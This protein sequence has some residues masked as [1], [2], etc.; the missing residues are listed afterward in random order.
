MTRQYFLDF[1]DD[2]M[3]S[4]TKH[5]EKV[6]GAGGSLDGDYS[7]YDVARPGAT[8][9]DNG[10]TVL[11]ALSFSVTDADATKL[12]K[13][14]LEGTRQGLAINGHVQGD[15]SLVQQ[16]SLS[17]TLAIFD[18]VDISGARGAGTTHNFQLQL[19]N[20]TVSE[21]AVV[22]GAGHNG[23]GKTVVTVDRVTNT[24]SIA[25]EPGAAPL[26]GADAAGGPAYDD[27]RYFMKVTQAGATRWVEIES[28]AF[29]IQRP[30]DVNASESGRGDVTTFS[31][32]EIERAV[33]DASHRFQYLA[34]SE[35]TSGR[36]DIQAFRNFGTDANPQWLLASEYSFAN[37][38]MRGDGKPF[39]A[40]VSSGETTAQG[41]LG[42]N[43]AFNV[44]EFRETVYSYAPVTFDLL[45]QAAIE[46]STSRGE[47]A[48]ELGPEP[49][50]A[51]VE[52]ETGDLPPVP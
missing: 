18:R 11:D 44:T 39:V 17:T 21:D 23:Q 42:E 13:A 19:G 22:T 24:E 5:P 30:V 8:S 25:S 20:M 9:G 12:V 3:N 35:A 28:F 40:S 46:S 26:T 7:V 1:T 52:P 6:Q 14:L 4:G 50:D 2:Q 33:D 15:N 32:L 45:K 16:T 48:A 34:E 10:A 37:A 38:P 31:S 29:S 27:Q 36:V 51:P 49:S 47:G 43:L 41:Q